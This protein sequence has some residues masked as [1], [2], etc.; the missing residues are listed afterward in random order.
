MKKTNYPLI[1]IGASI[2]AI[3]VIRTMR[4]NGDVRPILLIHGEDRLPY[5]RTKIN[6]HMVRGFEKEAFK[7]AD[8]KWYAD[9]DVTLLYDWVEGIDR[10]N[11]QVYTK[12]GHELSYQK[13][14]LA[15]GAVAVVPHI[16]GIDN[17]DVHK[18]QN[19]LDVDRLLG[20]CKENERFLIIGGGVEGIETADQLIRKGKQV[21]LANRMKYPL[22]K[23]FPE[24]IVNHLEKEMTKKGVILLGGVSVSTVQK[25]ADGSYT[26]TLKGKTYAFDAI[27]A[28][29]GAMP[30]VDL[31]RKANLKVERGVVVDAFMQ[32]NDPDILAAGDVA[33]HA[34]GVV[35][36]LWHAAEH[37]GELVA[38]NV[39]GNKEAHTLP[40][41][42]LKTEVFGLYLFSGAYENIVPG[43]DEAVEE[44][45]GAI[46]RILYYSNAKLKSA[47]FLG[48][49]ERAK[50]YQKALFEGWTKEQVQ[51][52]LPLPAQ[53][54]F[55]F[56]P[57]F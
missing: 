45:V 30:N 3:S 10:M 11:K 24:A 20:A 27:V 56:S 6:K 13:L 33:Q 4:Q 50:T 34:Q 23:L 43:Q 36:G 31:A 41:Y 35:T 46:H 57:S 16:S 18:V 49:G 54:T 53:P 9:N 15:T 42:R 12:L 8:E 2:T 26:L 29:T 21:I 39:L 28:C 22:L 40:P 52:K 14:V 48:D 1:I 5:K 38:L 44:Q 17:S 19:A 37:Q 7:M 47:V 55:S 51:T 25:Q 32:T